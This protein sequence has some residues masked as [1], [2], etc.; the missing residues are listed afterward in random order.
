MGRA[1]VTEEVIAGVGLRRGCAAVEIV[2]VVRTAV[3]AV[4]RPVVVLATPEFKRQESGLLV[5][6]RLLGVELL[7][8]DDQALHAAQSF[9]VT[10]SAV[11]ERAVGFASVAEACAIAAAAPRGQLLLPRIRGRGA[12]C[13]IAIRS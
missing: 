6:S 4:G 2:N 8:I 12:T 7:F 3:A 1:A 13:A 5:A 11:A 10:Y 9:C